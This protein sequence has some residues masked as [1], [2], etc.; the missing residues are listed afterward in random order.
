MNCL[1]PLAVRIQKIQSLRIAAEPA[2][3]NTTPSVVVGESAIPVKRNSKPSADNAPVN[4]SGNPERASAFAGYA[5][6]QYV[7]SLNCEN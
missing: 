3:G 4:N 5:S 6:S 1:R 7:S 2:T